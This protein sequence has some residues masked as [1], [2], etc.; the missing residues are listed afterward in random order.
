MCNS[1]ALSQHLLLSPTD[2]LREVKGLWHEILGSGPVWIMKLRIL[3]GGRGCITST[4]K[5]A[6]FSKKS[7]FWPK[8]ERSFC[9]PW[10]KNAERPYLASRKHSREER[11]FQEFQEDS[12]PVQPPTLWPLCLRVAHPTRLASLRLPP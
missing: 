3:A 9:I 12:D 5:S 11:V 4:P 6:N 8:N 2:R 10:P 7:R 1:A